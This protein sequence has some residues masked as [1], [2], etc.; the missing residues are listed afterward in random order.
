MIKIY[1]DK[2][3]IKKKYHFVK[4]KMSYYKSIR[5]KIKKLKRRL[6]NNKVELIKHKGNTNWTINQDSIKR[7]YDEQNNLKERIANLEN[8]S[9][10]IKK[11]LEKKIDLV[12]DEKST[13]VLELYYL[14]CMTFN[15]IC[16]QLYISET[17][18]RRWFSKGI[19]YIIE[20]MEENG[21]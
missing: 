2:K 1:N 15:D 9:N 20:E 14:N 18:G 6:H 3:N 11:D 21:C 7:L 12:P 17:T 8:Y 10:Q 4:D 16:D 19:Y 5:K 13:K